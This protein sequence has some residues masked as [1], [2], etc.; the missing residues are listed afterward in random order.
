MVMVAVGRRPRD[1]RF[2][3]RWII[4]MLRVRMG[5]AVDV[6]SNEH[7]GSGSRDIFIYL[8]S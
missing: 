6:K 1:G 4:E 2:M 8:V 5:H 7:L 3:L